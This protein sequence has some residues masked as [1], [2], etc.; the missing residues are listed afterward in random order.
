[1]EKILLSVIVPVYNMERFLPDCL[2][3]LISQTLSETEFICVNDG[4]TDLSEQILINYELRD[5]R[6]KVM[7]RENGGLSEARN[8]GMKCARG[9]YIC[10]LDSDDWLKKDALREMYNIA[11]KNDAE[12]LSFDADCYYESE[13]LKQKEYKDE[14]YHRKKSYGGPKDGKK[15][16]CELVEN[17]DFC[18]AAWIMCIKRDWLEKEK[19]L[20]YPGILHEDCLFS[21]QCY[22]NSKKIMHVKKEF[23]VYRIRENSIMTSGASHASMYGRLVCYLE[24]IKYLLQNDL[25]SDIKSSIASFATFIMYNIKYV[26]FALNHTERMKASNLEPILQMLADSME[27]GASGQYGISA[28]IYLLGFQ[29]LLKR[30]SKIILYGA[31]KI[32]RLVYKYIAT[33]KLDSHIFSFAVS[34]TDS[35]YLIEGI[36]LRNIDDLADEKEALVLITARKDYQMDMIYKAKTLGFDNIEVVDFRL[37][38]ILRNS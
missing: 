23:L 24:V 19:I 6:I 7:N 38:Q 30:H 8:T 36:P 4:S 12:I 26:D 16:F 5:K 25:T 13:D 37:E 29:E 35:N 20:F 18:D 10:F 14:Y 33:Q 21:F 32:G 2:D 1:M 27:V 31:G 34:Q 15:L 9:D 11:K 22:M 17:N 3:S 28:N